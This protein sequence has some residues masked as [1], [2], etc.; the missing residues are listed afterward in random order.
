[1]RRGILATRDELRALAGLAGRDAFKNIYETLRRRCAL[2][3]ESQPMTER[4]W[5]YLIAQGQWGSAFNAA[6]SVQGRALD[7][8]I[9][10]H[11]D[12]NP[13]YR[14][15]AVEEVNNLVAWSTWVD[16]SH[17]DNVADLCTAEA[18]VTVAIALDW[19][20][21]DLSAADRKRWIDALLNKAI[22]PYLQGVAQGAFW[23]NCYHYWNAAIN[24]GVGL[25]ALALKDESPDAAKGYATA[26]KQLTHFF[27]ALGRE[28]GWDEGTGFWGHA[29]RYILLLAESASRL[30]NDQGLYHARGMDATGLFPIYFT[31]NGHPASFGDSPTVPAHG[32]F[33][34]LA[35]QYAQREVTW[36]LDTY[37][38][39][40]DVGTTGWSTAGLA[41]LLRPPRVKTPATIK[42]EPVKVFADI[43]WAALAD[44]WPRPTFYVAAKTGDLAANHSQR[45][46]NSLQVQVDGE[47]LLNDSGNAPC[48]REYLAEPRDEF[49]VQARAHNT[50]VVAERDHQIDAQGRIV[51]SR[52][53]RAF[54]Y[55]ACDA[56]EAC[57]E[58]VRFL[59]HVVMLLDDQTRRG[60]ALVVLDDVLNGV[61]EKVELFWHTDGRIDLDPKTATGT[62][63]SRQ[64]SLNFAIASTVKMTT[65]TKSHQVNQH[66]HDK[67][68][69]TTGG[70][71]GRGLIASVFARGELGGPLE[72]TERGDGG[73]EVTFGGRRLTFKGGRIMEFVP[74]KAAR[75]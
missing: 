62:I 3:L 75:Q 37:G 64:V 24:G 11:I 36:W 51:A 58:N 28:G 54:R 49:E 42:L 13:A 32:A 14:E 45:D 63:A 72:V 52:R 60:E 56:G 44:A 2:V 33:Y 43:G 57:G 68:L 70:V 48:S 19:A 27:D 71:V 50:I 23:A 8:L 17:E 59:R 18:A 29:F 12:A 15:R 5:R 21:E 66:R 65:F 47:M 7:L 38:F 41:M 30:D 35:R 34:L 73:A 16:P 74:P 53:G 25:A 22:R 55:V 9:G 46:M 61:P 6:R 26:R 4:Q 20:W 69:T 10:H 1:M 31:P 39:H 67:V 40:R